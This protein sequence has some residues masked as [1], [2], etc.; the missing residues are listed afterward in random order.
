[1][2]VF[3]KKISTGVLAVGPGGECER[4]RN[5]ISPFFLEASAKLQTALVNAEKQFNGLFEVAKDKHLSPEEFDD[6][7]TPTVIE[8]SNLPIQ[9]MQEMGEK[10]ESVIGVNRNIV[11]Q[12]MSG[13]ETEFPLLNCLLVQLVDFRSE[14]TS[15]IDD[16]LISSQDLLERYRNGF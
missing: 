4:V 1:M 8:F 14:F 10:I 12:A 11:I 5:S 3:E 15:L 6:T 16:V 7:M 13:H 2:E 9:S